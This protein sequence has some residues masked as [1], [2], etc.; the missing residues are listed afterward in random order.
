[1]GDTVQLKTFAKKLLCKITKY[2]SDTQNSL[3]AMGI[4]LN[5]QTFMYEVL[6]P[7]IMTPYKFLWTYGGSGHILCQWMV[8]C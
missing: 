7:S 6:A 2:S 5:Q 3:D 8:K 4:S 1:M